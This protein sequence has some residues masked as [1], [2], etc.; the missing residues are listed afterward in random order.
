MYTSKPRQ[1]HN[2]N[3]M[4]VMAI[5]NNNHNNDKAIQITAYCSLGRM[6]DAVC[7]C[8]LVHITQCTKCKVHWNALWEW[9]YG[10]HKIAY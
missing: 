1:I 3:W 5:P 4:L 6:A 2:G 8:T 10:Q 9:F 7:M